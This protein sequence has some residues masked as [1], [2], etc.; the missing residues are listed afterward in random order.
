LFTR[1]VRGDISGVITVV[2]RVAGDGT[3]KRGLI[4]FEPALVTGRA[5]GNISTLVCLVYRGYS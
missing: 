1:N 3:V 5:S 2:V 4:A